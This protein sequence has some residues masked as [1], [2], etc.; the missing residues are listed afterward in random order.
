MVKGSWC[1]EQCSHDK[2]IREKHGRQGGFSMFL[3]S[4]VGKQLGI[5]LL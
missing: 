5:G 3:V 1:H 4:R 2:G